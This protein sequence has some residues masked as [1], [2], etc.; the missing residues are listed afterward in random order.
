MA[1]IRTPEPVANMNNYL[2]VCYKEFVAYSKMLENHFKN[3]QDMEFTIQ[4]GELFML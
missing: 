2:P 1:G 4:E 3:M